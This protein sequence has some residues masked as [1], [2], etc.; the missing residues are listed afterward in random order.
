MKKALPGF[1]ILL[2]VLLCSCSKKLYTHQQVM[3]SFHTK[4]DVFKRFGNPD[5]KRAVDST[6]TWIYNHDVSGKSQPLTAQTPPGS[7]TSQISHADIQTAYVNFMFDRNGNIIGY[8]S[9]GVD[10]SYV[11]NV[12]AAHNVL[13]VLGAAAIIIV[14]V[15]V[16]AYT[17]GDFNF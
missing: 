1:F 8:K 3:Q 7:D 11:K 2:F 17:N 13:N 9:N 10:L 14:V 15:G 4:D 12:S 5:I 6:E 16:E